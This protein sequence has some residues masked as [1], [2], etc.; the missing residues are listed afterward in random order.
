[1]Y[2]TTQI[3]VNTFNK[4]WIV[5]KSVGIYEHGQ[6]AFIVNGH[7]KVMLEEDYLSMTKHNAISNTSSTSEAKQSQVNQLGS[8]IIRAI[9]LPEI[10]KEIND[11][12]NFATL[13]QIFYAQALAV[14]FKRNLKKAL[15]NQVYANKGTVKG[16]DQNDVRTNELIY[17]QY[18]RAYKKGVFNFIQEDIDPV[19]QETMPRKYFSGGWDG[20]MMGQAEHLEALPVGVGDQATNFTDAEVLVENN[21]ADAAALS[22][23]ANKVMARPQAADAAM[24][25]RELLKMGLTAGFLF[26]FRA[27][28]ADVTKYE[29]VG[30]RHDAPGV[31]QEVAEKTIQLATKIRSGQISSKD[32]ADYK[33]FI[34]KILADGQEDIKNDVKYRNW[35]KRNIKSIPALG[36]ESSK[37]EL[38][39]DL[40]HIKP[41]MTLLRGIFSHIW[42][43]DSPERADQIGVYIFGA[44]E[45]LYEND[46]IK[47]ETIVPLD[48]S[49]YKT[50]GLAAKARREELLKQMSDAHRGD[51]ENFLKP[52]LEENKEPSDK[53][54][55]DR[56][57]S[58]SPADKTLA[59]QIIEATKEQIDFLWTKRNK[60]VVDGISRMPEGSVI[61]F[62]DAHGPRFKEMLGKMG[63]TVKLSEAK[64][65]AMILQK[66]GPQE[67][68][69]IVLPQE[70]ADQ[71]KGNQDFAM[72]GEFQPN[73]EH[74]SK[75]TL[76]DTDIPKAPEAAFWNT[77][78][79]EQGKQDVSVAPSMIETLEKMFP[80]SESDIPKLVSSMESLPDEDKWK[81]VASIQLAFESG[82]EH[83]ISVIQRAVDNMLSQI[84]QNEKIAVA[85][86][87]ERKHKRNTAIATIL[88][89]ALIF[90]TGHGLFHQVPLH[91]QAEVS[92][93]AQ[94]IN[95]NDHYEKV[96][97]EYLFVV[98]YHDDAPADY[99][100]Y[101]INPKTHLN[102]LRYQKDG[103]QIFWTDVGTGL[104]TKNTPPGFSQFFNEINK[105]P[106]LIFSA[107]QY[108][109]VAGAGEG[110]LEYE[111]ESNGIWFDDTTQSWVA[112]PPTGFSVKPNPNA[113]NPTES[114]I[115]GTTW[116]LAQD[117]NPQ[118]HYER[119]IG[120]NLFT[121]DYSD[122][123][124]AL[125][126]V[127]PINNPAHSIYTMN[128]DTH[129][130]S[131]KDAH[132]NIVED[133]PT[134][135]SEFF[136][137]INKSYRVVYGK[138]V[139]G[140]ETTEIYAADGHLNYSS[141]YVNDYL[142]DRD[143]QIPVSVDDLPGYSN[144]IN[145]MGGR[146]NANP[147]NPP[148][149][150]AML[151]KSKT[152]VE[153]GID[154]S[155]QDAAMHVVK[156]ANG[157]VTV[158]VDPALIERVEREGLSRVYPV[159]VDMH[160]ADAR[161]IFGVS[162]LA[163]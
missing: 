163:H 70:T 125:Y 90:S 148:G 47:S 131:W 91:P 145:S 18:L 89:W 50:K 75:N 6:T 94:I 81:M 49:D 32:V 4:V 141:D 43:A 133:I 34:E 69:E 46:T 113:K 64:D 153:G 105:S 63:I 27:V 77:V 126:K 107:G 3:P 13:R 150:G 33:I 86:A 87:R 117:V 101:E 68:K 106:R 66:V 44:A 40:Q 129:D 85:T 39:G 57:Q 132:G 28:R 48:N 93:A 15:L 20:A 37:E 79:P 29:I 115:N 159:I 116:I 103:R 160:P 127:F 9:I 65:K 143:K 108:Y 22:T 88:S 16:I 51:F 158:N 97:G 109:I 136:N 54:I 96:I 110:H 1:M 12:K 45:M 149:D 134:G 92:A 156:D 10:E 123:E 30:H 151:I 139:N 155:Q 118:T 138:D 25:R 162:V 114:H 71:N 56:I 130:G 80:G 120:N 112:H 146:I 147:A 21:G 11:G 35:V 144:F 84:K 42:P 154:L 152:D 58:Y 119:I 122:R 157:G 60:V 14:W 78:L 53:Q 124:A 7:L 36:V 62:G 17:H 128:A 111:T 5:P 102:H 76:K 121:V 38:E 23:N 59:P 26:A 72:Q 73:P 52:W 55:Q 61:E 142:F 95:V 100:A 2:G 24:T 74:H 31:A 161:S 19:T 137:G 67:L 135:F 104:R 98:D 41:F 99:Q 140:N 83:N 82:A 8:Q